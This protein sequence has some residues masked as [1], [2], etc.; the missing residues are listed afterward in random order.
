MQ[1]DDQPFCSNCGY[2]LTGLVESSKCP[3][4]GR[5]IVE[6]LTRRSHAPAFGKR[7]KSAVTVFGLPFVCIATGPSGTERYGHAK[8]IIAIGDVATGVVAIGGIAR[9]IVAI[10]GVAIGVAA[11]AGCA[12]GMLAAMGGVACG[13]LSAGGL[14]VGGISQGGLAIAYVADGG[15]AI[16]HFARGGQPRGTLNVRGTRGS[17]AAKAE[18]AKWTLFIG[19]TPGRPVLAIWCVGVLLTVALLAALVVAFGYVTA[20]GS[21]T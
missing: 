10:G 11:F 8:G 21:P 7:H 15:M 14:A 6:V 3:E 20:R 5:P 16:G 12:I 13:G 9:G 17:Q 1:V 4:C 18:E 2:Q 19:K